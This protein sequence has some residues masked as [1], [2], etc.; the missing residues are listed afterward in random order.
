[1][2][3]LTRPDAKGI[4]QYV[5]RYSTVFGTKRSPNHPHVIIHYEVVECGKNLF[6]LL[7]PQKPHRVIFEA[8]T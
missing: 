4:L 6:F 8:N 5:D 1:M 7:E 3:E 2:V